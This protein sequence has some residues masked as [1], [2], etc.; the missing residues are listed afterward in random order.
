MLYDLLVRLLEVFLV[1]I[2]INIDV[3]FLNFRCDY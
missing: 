3:F 2:V 1:N